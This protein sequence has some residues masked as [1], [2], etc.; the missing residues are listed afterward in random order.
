MP[1][2]NGCS[3]VFRGGPCARAPP[4]GRT[5]VIFVTILEL[6]LAPLRDKIA[7]TS[8]QMRFFSP[9]N[10]LK[11]VCGRGS[12]TDPAGGA[13]SAPPALPTCLLLTHV[14]LCQRVRVRDVIAR[15]RYINVL[16]DS[17]TYISSTIGCANFGPD[18]PLLFK[19]HE[20]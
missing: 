1:L 8:D 4:L 20:I 19:V 17:L 7:A 6:F 13:Y 3:G 2:V 9:E 15:T 10:A 5:A 18:W 11:C 14:A 12:A 16:T